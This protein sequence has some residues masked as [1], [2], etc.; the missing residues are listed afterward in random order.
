MS[1]LFDLTKHALNLLTC[2]TP[3]KAYLHSLQSVNVTCMHNRWYEHM[4]VRNYKGTR[5]EIQPWLWSLNEQGHTHSSSRLYNTDPCLNQ[6]IP[7]R[8][9]RQVNLQSL[10]P[11]GVYFDTVISKKIDFY[12]VSCKKSEAVQM[13]QRCFFIIKK[14]LSI[15]YISAA[16]HVMFNFLVR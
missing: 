16:M 14:T 2:K 4:H 5:S 3:T 10:V 12:N 7:K 6:N 11:T 13:Y 8:V 15:I 1:K 9:F